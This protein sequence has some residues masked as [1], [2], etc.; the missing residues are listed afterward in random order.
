M[1]YNKLK[2]QNHKIAYCESKTLG[3]PVLF[4]HGNSLSAESYR[5]QLESDLGRNYRLIAFDLP[6]HGESEKAKDP[7]EIYRM[8]GFIGF[9][10]ELI[11][12]L[13][14][15]NAVFIGHSMGGHMLI[16]AMDRLPGA[17]GFVIFG[18]PPVQKP[19]HPMERSYFPNPAFALAF[20][21]MLTPKELQ[22]LSSAYVAEGS[23]VPEL[24]KT[25]LQKVDTLMRGTFGANTG[26]TNFPDEAGIIR[27]MKKPFAVFHGE[28][29]QMI[30]A[31]Y[32]DELEMP[33]LWRNEVQIIMKAGH[34]PQIENPGEFNVLLGEFLSKI[35]N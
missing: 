4:V 16:D 32:F 8:E 20:K 34:C 9:M 13:K 5:Y 33:T 26:V 19:D 18:A 27:N 28:A 30:R 2:I 11:S 21:G 29:D 1:K 14:I 10:L 24:I 3:P 31:T 22:T 6:G 17:S 7:Q 23:K 12:T 15:E 25:S 35:Y